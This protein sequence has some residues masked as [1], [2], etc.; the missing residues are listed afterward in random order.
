[1]N[2]AIPKAVVAAL[3]VGWLLIWVIAARNVNS[4][5]WLESPMSRRLHRIP[6]AL[7]AFLLAAPRY[8]PQPF[9]GRLLPADSIVDILGMVMVLCGLGFAVWARCYLRPNWGANVTLKGGHSLVRTGPPINMSGTRSIWE[10]CS[11]FA[12]RRP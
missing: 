8:L 3:W 7:A 6:L 1:M 12:A 5:R 4:T 11:E 10:S 9:R 2:E